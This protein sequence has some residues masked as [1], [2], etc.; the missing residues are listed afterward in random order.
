MMG[1]QIGGIR[2]NDHRHYLTRFESFL[3]RWLIKRILKRGTYCAEQSVQEVMGIVVD[4]MQSA[5]VKPP[6]ALRHTI[7][8]PK[9]KRCFRHHR[10]WT[11]RYFPEIGKYGEGWHCAKCGE[12]KHAPFVAFLIDPTS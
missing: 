10:L 7:V 12:F 11:M 3:T 8:V 4:E 6:Y 1:V 2:V 5:G 9:R